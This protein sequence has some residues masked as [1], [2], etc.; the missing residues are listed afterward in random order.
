MPDLS[1]FRRRSSDTTNGSSVTA[2]T[3]FADEQ[4][5][6]QGFPPDLELTR[7]RKGWQVMNTSA[8]AGLVVRPGTTANLTLYNGNT[9]ASGIAMIV[10][11]VFAFNLVTTAAL[12]GWSI[13]G[14][15]HPAGMTA[16]TADITTVNSTSGVTTYAGAAIVDTG[17]TVVDNGWFPIGRPFMTGGVT[18]APSGAIA[19]D[20]GWLLI[21]PTGGMSLQVVSTITGLTFTTGFHFYETQVPLG[22]AS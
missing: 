14:C 15:I 4:L 13:W 17:A 3:N 8:L 16:P 10:R 1:S 9:T 5:V 2:V 19:E 11:R 21:P 6:S 18:T 22:D 20:V 12:S 7:R